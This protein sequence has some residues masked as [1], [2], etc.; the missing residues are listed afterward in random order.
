MAWIKTVCLQK[1]WMPWMAFWMHGLI[2][3]C[4]LHWRTF[5]A[6]GNNTN[7]KKSYKR[8]TKHVINTNSQFVTAIIII[9]I[10]FT[11]FW[12]KSIEIC[13]GKLPLCTRHRGDFSCLNTPFMHVFPSVTIELVKLH[14]SLKPHLYTSFSVKIKDAAKISKTD[15]QPLFGTTFILLMLFIHTKRYQTVDPSPGIFTNYLKFFHTPFI[16]SILPKPL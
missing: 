14:Y 11:L 5:V 9:I 15:D 13:P 10:S 1:V 16:P 7:G 6:L 3:Y 4:L 2:D 12:T 8:K